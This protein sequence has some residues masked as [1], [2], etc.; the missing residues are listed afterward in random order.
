MGQVFISYSHKDSNYAMRLAGS[1]EALG[2]PYW[3]DH[4]RLEGGSEWSKEIK[5]AIE[6]S[7]IVVVIMTPD[8]ETS[9]WVNQEI[10]LA[11]SQKK[12]IFPLLLSGRSLSRLQHVQY[13]SVVNGK[14][15]ME[16]FYKKV[17][18]FLTPFLTKPIYSFISSEHRE[19]DLRLLAKLW[20]TINSE[21][22]SSFSTSIN[23][24]SLTNKRFT[25]IQEYLYARETLHENQFIIEE[26]EQAFVKFDEILAELLHQISTYHD[27]MQRGNREMLVP[28]YKLP[29]IRNDFESSS[30]DIF[31]HKLKEHEKTIKMAYDMF[32]KHR[33]LVSAIKKCLP[34]FSFPTNE[35]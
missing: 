26:L 16:S 12:N 22:M 7:T 35:V 1:F 21:K 28:H 11:E 14:L 34:E 23:Y 9:E 30:D 31:R 25:E 32:E 4:I 19:A 18:D 13:F 8:A 6:R 10:R 17:I 15:P 2:I 20:R 27:I 29:E 3:I 33:D 5:D 24:R